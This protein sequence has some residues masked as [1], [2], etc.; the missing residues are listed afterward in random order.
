MSIQIKQ[1]MSLVLD[2]LQQLNDKIQSIDWKTIDKW[3][4]SSQE[5]V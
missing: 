3:K 4:P 1:R 5:E 2:T